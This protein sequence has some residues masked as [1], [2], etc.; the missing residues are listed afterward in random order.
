M[1]DQQVKQNNVEVLTARPVRIKSAM[2]L[3]CELRFN[4]DR[5]AHVVPR[6][7]G[8]VESSLA[9]DGARVRKGPV[10]QIS[11]QAPADQRS[12]LLAA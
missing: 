4:E 7:T 3:I 10:P 6:L 5:V 1:S 2:Q 12:E 11:L 9:N 8:F